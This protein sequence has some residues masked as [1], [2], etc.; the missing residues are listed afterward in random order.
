[1]VR[2]QAEQRLWRPESLEHEGQHWSVEGLEL[3]GGL[4]IRR[5]T[6]LAVLQRRF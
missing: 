1:L 4:R 3:D 5:G 2:R 6:A